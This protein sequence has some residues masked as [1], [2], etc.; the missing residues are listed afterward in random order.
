MVDRGEENYGD[1]FHSIKHSSWV[2]LCGKYEKVCG[3][4]VMVMSEADL[5]EYC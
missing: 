1:E 3:M 5:T 2:F 4:L